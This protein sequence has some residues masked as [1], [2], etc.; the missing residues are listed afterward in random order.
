MRDIAGTMVVGSSASAPEDHPATPDDAARGVDVQDRSQDHS[1]G[2]AAML[3]ETIRLFIKI[4]APQAQPSP[5]LL[6]FIGWMSV[7]CETA[8]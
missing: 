4:A 3:E 1:G 6:T 2:E 8:E 5:L 7:T